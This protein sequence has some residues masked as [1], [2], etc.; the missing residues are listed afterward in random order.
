MKLRLPLKIGFAILVF[1][2]QVNCFSQVSSSGFPAFD[3]LARSMQLYRN[4]DSLHSFCL[5]PIYIASNFYF[6]SVYG[7][8]GIQG[9][10]ISDNS[11]ASKQ[12]VILPLTLNQQFNAHHPYGW[13][14]GSM[15]PARGYEG[16]LSFGIFLRKGVFS[17]Q[18]RPEV[19]FAQNSSF[20]GFSS[21]QT[22]SL[23]KAYYDAVLNVID[24]PE[25][26]GLHSYSKIFPGQSNLSINYHKLR[27][28]LS[29][30]NLWWGPGVR[31][32][33]LMSNNAPGFP[34]ISFNSTE[35]VSTVI[36]SFEWQL[37]SGELK[38][39]GIL[40]ED[41]T[42]K[43][44]GQSLYQAKENGDR[45]LNGVVLSWQPKWTNGLFIGFSRVFYQ[46]RSEVSPSLD[47]YMP[48][49][50]KVFKKKLGEEDSKKR[51]Q[52]L[53]FF[54][55]FTLPKEKAEFYGEFGRNDHAWD[56]RD[57]LTEPEH[58][59]AY[60]IGFSKI[61]QRGKKDLQLFSEISNLQIPSTN[62][63][64]EQQSWY[65]H[66]QVRHGYTNYGQ[67][68][69]AGIGP[70]GSS[71]TIGLEWGREFNKLGGTI[72]RVVRNND[73]YYRAFSSSR[74][75]QKHWVDISLNLNKTWIKNRIVYNASISLVHSLNYQW[76]Y[77]DVFNSSLRFGVS[78]LF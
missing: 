51:D 4:Y 69:G 68:I 18:L 31:N 23:W 6:D 72:E 75:W 39:S 71:Q 65:S 55:R 45:Y 3:E 34:H 48:V 49:V 41:T 58:S 42:R 38:G 62:L 46:Y 73:F 9:N 28:D 59:R 52:I 43:I 54:F 77:N 1:Q 10:Q 67:V 47:G 44:N 32:S 19:V 56:L 16:Q 66:Y 14:D 2:I 17:L 8:Q 57:F 27:L 13:N 26:F 33:L 60:I 7:K 35:P 5:R 15:I 74:Q 40:P 36:G 21:M 70:G 12:F 22:D 63:L 61:F 30:Q 11:S 25:K 78:Y 24:A 50:T 20:P 53:S 37:I 76:F 64:R 29:T